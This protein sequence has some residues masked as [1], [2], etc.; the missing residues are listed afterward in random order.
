MRSMEDVVMD[1][2]AELLAP[3]ARASGERLAALIA[4][5]FLEVG[6]AGQSFGKAEVLA[7][8]PYESGVTFTTGSMRAHALAS[9]VVLVTYSVQRTHEGHSASSKR[10]SLWVKGSDGWQMRYHQGTYTESSPFDG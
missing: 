9:T 6:A 5:D 7:R 2:E 3:G 10:S 4:E 8:L 1:L